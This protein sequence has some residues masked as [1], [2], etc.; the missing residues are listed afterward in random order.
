MLALIPGMSITEAGEKSAFIQ[1]ITDEGTAN[2]PYPYSEFAASTNWLE[3]RIGNS[4][5]SER[6]VKIDICG[7]DI[8]LRGSAR[9]GIPTYLKY[10]I[11]GPF[12]KLPFMECYHGV[13]SLFHIFKGEFILNGN[14]LSMEHGVGYIEKDWGKSFPK[15]YL[16]VQCNYFGGRRI[17]VMASVADIPILGKYF[18]G[19]ICAVYIDGREYRMATYNGV[20]ILRCDGSGLELK[21]GG[22]YLKVELKQSSPHP[23]FAPQMGEMH[24]VIHENAACRARFYFARDDEVLLDM[25]SEK[26]SFEYAWHQ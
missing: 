21:R 1:V 11:M 19:C 13:V 4:Y 8:E 17:S 16:W 5:F 10:D 6:G 18:R 24:R 3:V 15:N 2:V 7:K 9:Y 23:L 12:G 22:L 14:N 26:A 20:R 25:E